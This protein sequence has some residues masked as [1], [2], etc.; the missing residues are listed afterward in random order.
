MPCKH[1]WNSSISS[2]KPFCKSTCCLSHYEASDLAKIGSRGFNAHSHIFSIHAVYRL[3]KH[4]SLKKPSN[5][6]PLPSN[7]RLHHSVRHSRLPAMSSKYKGFVRN[8]AQDSTQAG[9]PSAHCFKG[10]SVNTAVQMNMDSPSHLLAESLLTTRASSAPTDIVDVHARM[11]T[12]NSHLNFRAMSLNACG[13]KSTRA[14]T[15]ITQATGLQGVVYSRIPL[16]LSGSLSACCS[17]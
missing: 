2:V 7:L 6:G 1:Y 12:S 13:M 17:S 15:Y 14:L 16:N 9:L 4:T 5:S 11:C 10:K 3:C 8:D